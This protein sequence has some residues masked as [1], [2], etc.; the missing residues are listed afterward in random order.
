M[1]FVSNLVPRVLERLGMRLPLSAVGK[2]S[3]IAKY[4]PL[5]HTDLG[6]ITKCSVYIHVVLSFHVKCSMHIVVCVS[7]LEGN[8]HTHTAG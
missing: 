5:L 4:E 1:P 3:F 2:E 6:R 8:T 7:C